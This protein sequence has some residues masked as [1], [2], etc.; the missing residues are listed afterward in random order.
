[1]PVKD[2]LN[3]VN[4]DIINRIFKYTLVNQKKYK[5]DKTL[6]ERYKNEYLYDYI[7]NTNK[8]IYNKYADECTHKILGSRLMYDIKTYRK[9]NNYYGKLQTIKKSAFKEKVKN[10]QF[11]TLYIRQEVIKTVEKI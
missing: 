10:F 8:M 1:M 6:I 9:S 5:F 11:K 7:K 2:E 3:K 4:I